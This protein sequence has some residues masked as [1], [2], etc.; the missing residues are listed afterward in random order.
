MVDPQYVVIVGARETGQEEYEYRY[1]GGANAYGPFTREQAFKFSQQAE[2]YIDNCR[3]SDFVYGEPFV[4]LAPFMDD[5]QT[6]HP[7]DAVD[8]YRLQPEEV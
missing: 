6:A 2:E 3:S 5:S 8:H 4:I 7:F 1:C